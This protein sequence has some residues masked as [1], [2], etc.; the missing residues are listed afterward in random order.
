MFAHLSDSA[1]GL[2]DN[3]KGLVG[4]F[5][6]SISFFFLFFFSHTIIYLCLFFYLNT[7]T[8]HKI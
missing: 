8:L 2:G 4:F 1:F 3:A 7:E 6:S 5:F